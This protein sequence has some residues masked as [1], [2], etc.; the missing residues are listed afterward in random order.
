MNKKI[1]KSAPAAKTKRVASGR[2]A[3]S[4]S[5]KPLDKKTKAHTRKVTTARQKQ[6]Q[7]LAEVSAEMVPRSKAGRS[8]FPTM[9]LTPTQFE[10]IAQL[11]RSRE[12]AKKAARFVLVDGMRIVDAAN[13]TKVGGKSVSPQVVNNTVT[14]YKVAHTMICTGYRPKREDAEPA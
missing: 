2:S 3:A 7:E 6:I 5:K 4:E 14:R 11:I 13:M 8:P 12:P 9:R 10:I 1:T